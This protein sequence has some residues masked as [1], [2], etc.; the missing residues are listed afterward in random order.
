LVEVSHEIVN[1]VPA[2]AASERA[3]ASK[4]L[5]E[6]VDARVAEMRERFRI[7][8]KELEHGMQVA[9]LVAGRIARRSSR[10][11]ARFS[12]WKS[13]T[14][15]TTARPQP[16]DG[17]AEAC[18]RETAGRLALRAAAVALRPRARE[19]HRAPSA[20]AGIMVW[21]PRPLPAALE[22]LDERGLV[23]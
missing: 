18:S 9:R 13:L 3:R 5:V 11:I 4:P 19:R 6:L 15:R 14:A 7:M 16:L 17:G 1:S 20:L 22:Q 23:T 8:R 12:V 10:R 21:R 2:H